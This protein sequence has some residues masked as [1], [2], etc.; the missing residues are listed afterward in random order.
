MLSSPAG[1]PTKP[2]SRLPATTR[3]VPVRPLLPSP[4]P[5]PFPAHNADATETRHADVL[6]STQLYALLLLSNAGSDL[7]TYKLR[8]WTEAASVVGQVVET[9]TAAEEQCLFEVRPF[10]FSPLP[11]GIC[12]GWLI[13]DFLRGCTA[14]R[15]PLGQHP[16][17]P[18]PPLLTSSPL[19]HPQAPQ[20]LLL[21]LCL[22]RH[23]Q[24]GAV[25]PA[26]LLIFCRQLA[27]GG[28]GFEAGSYGGGVGDQG[29]ID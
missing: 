5:F 14:P 11:S 19:P 28:G 7:E 13:D 2:P 17:L 10:L 27:L 24:R 1:T 9:L 6:P 21:P 26:P 4:S 25:L 23:Q 29:D 18:H 3:S 8:N 12:Q 16:P 22:R 20:A 15:S